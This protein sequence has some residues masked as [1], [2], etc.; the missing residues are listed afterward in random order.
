[1]KTSSER[2]VLRRNVSRREF[3]KE[4]LEANIGYLT[5]ESRARKED[6]ECFGDVLEEGAFFLQLEMPTQETLSK[7][8]WRLV[9]EHRILAEIIHEKTRD[10]CKDVPKIGYSAKATSGGPSF[11]GRV[12]T[13]FGKEPV[14]VKWFSEIAEVIRG[15]LL[16]DMFLIHYNHQYNLMPEYKLEKTWRKRSKKNKKSKTKNAKSA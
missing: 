7:L 14:L 11:G 15:T 6:V 1:M 8:W 13:I 3:R 9:V 2:E 12:A 16:T 5:P 10:N 4:L